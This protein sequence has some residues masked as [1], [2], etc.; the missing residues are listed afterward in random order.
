MK[1][2]IN[3]ILSVDVDWVTNYSQFIN[4]ISFLN[5]KF[6]KCSK[7]ILIEAHHDILNYLEPQEDFIVN[8][9]HHHDITEHI[10]DSPYAKN[11]HM[12]NWVDYLI[13][14][15]KL[16]HY[17]WINNLD[18]YVVDYNINSARDLKTFK[19][20]SSLDFIDSLNFEK[21][22]ICKSFDFIPQSQ[23]DIGL[24]LTYE[25]LKSIA[26]NIFKEKVIISN[27]PNPYKV[28]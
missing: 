5:K 12:G 14:H 3:P 7:I 17:I 11:V 22:I 9:D 27:N 19:M 24:G 10:I 25:V 1:N 13:R 8:I 16:N 18:S 6:I 20:D 15:K 4:L 23:K 26:L 21:I 2:N 28:Y